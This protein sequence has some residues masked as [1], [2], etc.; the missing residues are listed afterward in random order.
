MR[1]QFRAVRSLLIAFM[2]CAVAVVVAPAAASAADSTAADDA[3]GSITAVASKADVTAANA[4]VSTK[5]AVCVG[6]YPIDAYAV[7]YDCNVISTTTFYALCSDGYVLGPL[8]LPAGQWRV[9]ADCYPA[10]FV[11]LI[12]V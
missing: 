4:D 9:Y 6:P 1:S 8:T 11:D 10:A 3:R 7:Y 12:V 2:L 5:V